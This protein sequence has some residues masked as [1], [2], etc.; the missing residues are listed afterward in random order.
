MILKSKKATEITFEIKKDIKRNGEKSIC[1]Y[2]YIY[3]TSEALF[4]VK[5][6]PSIKI[7]WLFQLRYIT[8]PL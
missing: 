5:L 4:P 1:S 3:F 8:P 2:L 7:F 6:H